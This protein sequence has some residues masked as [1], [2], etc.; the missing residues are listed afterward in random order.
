M[1]LDLVQLDAEF[2]KAVTRVPRALSLAEMRARYALPDL[3][4]ALRQYFGD[5]RPQALGDGVALRGPL[6]YALAES[7]RARLWPLAIQHKDY[8]L[9][10]RLM[11]IGHD[12]DR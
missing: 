12:G 1:S 6:L 5:T 3:D 8:A 10:G 11:S 9:A 7:E 4:H 2:Y